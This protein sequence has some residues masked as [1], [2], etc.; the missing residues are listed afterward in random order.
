MKRG[1]TGAG[2]GLVFSGSKAIFLEA[3]FAENILDT[4]KVIE[5]TLVFISEVRNER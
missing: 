2:T 4:R 5:I 3:C 1:L